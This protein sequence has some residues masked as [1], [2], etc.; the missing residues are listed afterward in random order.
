[1]AEQKLTLKE[2][3]ARFEVTPRALR[4]Y[5]YIELL[6]PEKQGRSRFYGAREVARLK[7]ILR[8][9]RFGFPLETVRQ[10]LETY[11]ADPQ[12]RLQTELWV[13]AAGEQISELESRKAELEETIA[14]L[15]ALRQ[16]SIDALAK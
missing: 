3:C 1:M 7:L 9:R 5:E 8:G 14:D 4:H 12:N 13:K 10:W 11:D 16:I 15:R 6:F 2:M